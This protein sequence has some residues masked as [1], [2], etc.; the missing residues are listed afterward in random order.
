MPRAGPMDAMMSTP[1]IA[2]LDFN[3]GALSPASLA[4]PSVRA[5]VFTCAGILLFAAGFL[6]FRRAVG[7]ISTP[8]SASSLF[9]VGLAVAG[10]AAAARFVWRRSGATRR[11]TLIISGLVTVSA[12]ATAAA[13]SLPESA[14]AGL[15]GLWL[16]VAAEE[17]W[18]WR[19]RRFVRLA[20]PAP[21]ASPS[22]RPVP[23]HGSRRQF[24]QAVADSALGLDVVQEHVTQQVT[25]LAEPDGTERVV[26]WMRVSFEPG[27]RLASVHLAFCPPFQR[28]PEAA[29][30]RLDGPEVRIKRVQAFPFGA[31]FDLKLD[32]PAEQRADVLLQVAAEV[33]GQQAAGDVTADGDGLPG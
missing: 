23:I 16:I 13:T 27:Q 30:E 33:Q 22:P 5:A 18:A 9:A 1:A 10:A 14:P 12:L 6:W 28:T 29:L 8:L 4:G 24:E 7:A 31:R 11:S 20:Q 32:V 25:R 2:D 15:A 26:G 3:A 19:P 21:A 17:F